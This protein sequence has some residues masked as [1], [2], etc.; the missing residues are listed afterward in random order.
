[1]KTIS[2][3]AGCSWM[4]V[5]LADCIAPGSGAGRVRIEGSLSADH[6]VTFGGILAHEPKETMTRL[7]ETVS[8][9]NPPEVVLYAIEASAIR[10]PRIV[11]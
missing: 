4:D 2:L 10:I 1:M 9:R 6:F 8:F 11:D 7:Q 5:V 3:Y